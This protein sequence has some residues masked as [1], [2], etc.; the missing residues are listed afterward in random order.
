VTPLE[1]QLGKELRTLSLPGV[2]TVTG[3]ESYLA[4]IRLGLGLAQVPRFHVEQELREGT[5]VEIL[6][7]TPPPSAPVSL[8]YARGRQ[9]APRVR[10][11]LEWAAQEFRADQ[12]AVTS[13][14]AT[15]SSR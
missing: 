10:A 7:D 6:K 14:L 11:F 1:F 9:L 5:L 15:S 2:L 13:S 4:G 12:A 3:T 8:L